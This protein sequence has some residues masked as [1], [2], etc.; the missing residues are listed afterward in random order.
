MCSVDAHHGEQVHNWVC[1]PTD[2][3][4]DLR[5]ANLA[6]ENLISLLVSGFRKAD[7]KLIDNVQ[8]EHHGQEP[9]HPTWGE[10]SSD[11]ELAVVARGNHESRTYAEGPS[12][13][14]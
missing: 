10:I 12:L 14:V 8:E 9:A 7:E 11:N 1:A 6:L 2:D 3:G 4:H 13:V 5:T